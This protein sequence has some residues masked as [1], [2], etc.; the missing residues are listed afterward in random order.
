MHIFLKAFILTQMLLSEE[1]HMMVV[2]LAVIYTQQMNSEVLICLHTL[3][4]VC[5]VCLA[6]SPYYSV[7]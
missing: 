2:M 5:S 3:L 7:R 1:W 6:N 4:C